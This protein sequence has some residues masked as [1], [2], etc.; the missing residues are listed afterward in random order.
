[1]AYKQNPGRGPM[2]KTGKGVPSALLQVDPTDPAKKKK[3]EKS[4]TKSLPAIHK[5]INLKQDPNLSESEEAL[6]SQRIVNESTWKKNLATASPR[7]FDAKWGLARKAQRAKDSAMI[8][9]SRVHRAGATASSLGTNLAS[10]TEEDK[11]NLK[12]T[13]NKYVPNTFKRGKDGNVK[14]E[15]TQRRKY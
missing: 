1:M 14:V 6:V 7:T 15:N 3:D 9:N 5:G 11:K 2:M 12:T 4:G 13:F 10:V 8:V